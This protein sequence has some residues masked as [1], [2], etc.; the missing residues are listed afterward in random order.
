M[1]GEEAAAMILE[2]DPAAKLFVSSGYSDNTVI[3]NYKDYGFIDFLQK[4]YDAAVLDK[5][6][7]TVIAEKGA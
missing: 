2:L 6:L 4:P 3:S 1:G 7:R 5:K